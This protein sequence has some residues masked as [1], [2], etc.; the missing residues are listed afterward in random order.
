MR[1][2]S[3]SRCPATLALDTAF[4]VGNRVLCA[5]F[6]STGSSGRRE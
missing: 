1:Q 4:T 5:A 2:V 3:C 6:V